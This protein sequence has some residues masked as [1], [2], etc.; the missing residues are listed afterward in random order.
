MDTSTW[1]THNNT[2]THA[3]RGQNE[4]GKGETTLASLEALTRGLLLQPAAV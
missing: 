1:C 2:Y 4:K 3:H